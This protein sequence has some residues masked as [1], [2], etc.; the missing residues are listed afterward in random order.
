[1]GLSAIGSV[2][3]LQFPYADMHTFKKRPAVVIAHG[4][5]DTVIVCQITSQQLKNVPMVIITYEDFVSGSLPVTS[6]ARPDKLYT[7]D[8]G[9]AVD[10]L[11]LL[12]PEK[13]K[14]IRS[15]V[16]GLFA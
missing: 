12:K 11:G 3:L 13:T 10:K 5:L 1:M 14:Q 2:I 4:S 15:H 9:L 16:S 7:I 6:Y 8:D